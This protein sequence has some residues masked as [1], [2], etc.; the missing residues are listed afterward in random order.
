M[1]LRTAMPVLERLSEREDGV[2]EY[3]LPPPRD[4]RV[5]D[6]T[7]A[8][9]L[10]AIVVASDDD[11]EDL[12]E[13]L[14]A[15]HARVLVHENLRTLRGCLLSSDVDLVITDAT[16]PDANWADVLRLIVRASL[17]TDL[18]VHSRTADERLRSEVMWRGASGI[19]TPPYSIKSLRAAA[20]KALPW[21]RRS[22]EMAPAAAGM[23]GR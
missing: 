2:A 15:L 20:R 7:T 23:R 12:T 4:D 10:V 6:G 18:L 11:R 17:A 21:V 5:E 22:A 16:L 13:A 3:N 8:A 9:P 1:A 14:R 19:L